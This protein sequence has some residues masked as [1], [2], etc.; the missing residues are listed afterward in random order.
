MNN[1]YKQYVRILATGETGENTGEVKSFLTYPQITK[2][3]IIVGNEIR[4]LKEKQFRLL[5]DIR[6][7]GK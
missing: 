2:Y 1:L 6:K 7:K 4:W 5:S 3:K